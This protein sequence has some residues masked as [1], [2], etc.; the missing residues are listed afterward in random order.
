M[1]ARSVWIL[2]LMPGLFSLF[3][4]GSGGGGADAGVSGTYRVTNVA[5]SDRQIPVGS[6]AD[7]DVYFS[8]KTNFG[9]P[10]NVQVVL[11]LPASLN[12]FEASARVYAGSTL[13]SS[14]RRD[15]ND[16]ALCENGETYI[17]FNLTASDLEADGPT[18]TGSDQRLAVTVT[19]VQPE[20]GAALEALAGASTSYSCSNTF[21]VQENEIADVVQ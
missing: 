20:S 2:A 7:V 14:R 6:E 12:Y 5:A 8:T 11:R 1:S 21:E 13:E 10:M 18:R 16:I 19:A 17:F 4:C 15:P 9:V 3:G